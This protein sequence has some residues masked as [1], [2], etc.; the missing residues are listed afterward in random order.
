MQALTRL[1]ATGVALAISVLAACEQAPRE[2]APDPSVYED[3]VPVAE[4]ET[5]GDPSVYED[6]PSPKMETVPGGEATGADGRAG[7]A[8]PESRRP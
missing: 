5:V 1:R 6:G 7:A 2:P 3:A 4:T 8:D